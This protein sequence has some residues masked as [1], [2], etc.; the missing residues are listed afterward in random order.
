MID[1]FSTLKEEG[2]DPI[3][4]ALSSVSELYAM[5]ESKLE[6]HPYY[7]REMIQQRATEILQQVGLQDRVDI[8]PA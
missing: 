8:L 1:L 7:T 2:F 3:K 6:V 5:P 4:I